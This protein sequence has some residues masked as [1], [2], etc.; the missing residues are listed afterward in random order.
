MSPTT[1]DPHPVQTHQA[2]PP[3]GHAVLA[4]PVPALDAVVRER[5]A[6]YDPSFVS[7]DPAFVHAHITLLAP[8]LAEPTAADL[9]A[10]SA[11]AAAHPAVEVRLAQ[12]REFPGGVIH[13]APEPD[14]TFRRLTEALIAAFPHCPPYGG[15]FPEPTPHLTLDHPAGG[16]TLDEVAARVAPS[17][18]V[19]F[20]ADRIDLQWWA[21][22]DCRLLRSWPLGTETSR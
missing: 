11:I 8:W 19:T 21:N 15:E 6:Y 17:L 13:L 7:A 2:P 14:T 18:P 1:T 3:A 16:V 12:V 5:T 22:D 10:V 4:I 20:T 9:A